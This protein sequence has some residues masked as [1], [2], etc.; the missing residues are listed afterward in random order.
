[1][2]CIN[3][4]TGPTRAEESGLRAAMSWLHEVAV[5]HRRFLECDVAAAKCLAAVA[6]I[7]HTT[8]KTEEYDRVLTQ[9]TV[10]STVS[11]AMRNP[12][13]FYTHALEEV[14][15][16][17]ASLQVEEATFEHVQAEADEILLRCADAC[18]SSAQPVVPSAAPR[19]APSLP[20]E[21]VEL[22]N[23]QRL[24]GPT[25]G[26]CADSHDVFLRCVLGMPNAP[27]DALVDECQMLL[28]AMPRDAIMAHCQLYEQ[29]CKLVERKRIAVEA[30][31]VQRQADALNEVALQR[32]REEQRKASMQKENLRYRSDLSKQR[33]ETAE[34]IEHW[35]RMKEE[36][37]ARQRQS[38][39]LD[40]ARERH[41][42]ELQRERNEQK[43]VLLTAW[44]TVKHARVAATKEV[45]PPEPARPTSA[46]LERRWFDDAERAK[47]R[48]AK[49]QLIKEARGGHLRELRQVLYSE[50]HHVNA[51]VKNVTAD[52]AR[53]QRHTESSG[54]RHGRSSSVA[55]T[56]ENAMLRGVNYLTPRT[57]TA[58]RAA[59][60]WC[61][62]GHLL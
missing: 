45:T 7:D 15:N 1:M 40:V 57:L 60:A 47:Q 43:K 4:P 26:W 23:F 32:L 30:W 6:G 27:Q 21:F 38:K 44:K 46:Q 2:A 62:R 52:S 58:H 48:S 37:A 34:K 61:G 39:A 54:N 49:A 22:D 14:S 3:A 41:Q 19:P 53:V 18:E 35:R 17:L 29:Y 31:R 24:H 11:A 5:L 51:A 20:Q 42:Q 55:A 13:R 28:P 33:S 8:L 16:E 25:L 12:K 10:L 9:K 50:V 59:P 36:E 56:G